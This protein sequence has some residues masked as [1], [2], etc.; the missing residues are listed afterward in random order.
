MLLDKNYCSQVRKWKKSTKLRVGGLASANLV[1][2]KH[3]QTISKEN[4]HDI[5][6]HLLNGKTKWSLSPFETKTL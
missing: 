3:Q 1:M 4:K 5:I 2:L 6:N